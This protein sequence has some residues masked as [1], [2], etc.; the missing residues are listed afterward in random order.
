MSKLFRP[1]GAISVFLV[2][3]LVPCL[4]L[5]FLYVDL[6]RIELS[7]SSVESTADTALNS[8]MAN[9]DTVLNEYY[10]LIAS[11]QDI[12]EYCT[13]SK[14]FFV[15]TLQANGVA[16]DQSNEI[17]S[18]VFTQMQGGDFS[19]ILQGKLVKGSE[20]IYAVENSGLGENPALIKEGVVE[21]MKYRA[22]IM[23]VQSI[24]DLLM[25]KGDTLK[26]D[27]LEAEKDAELSESRDEFSRTE[28]ELNKREF[29]TYYYYQVYAHGGNLANTSGGPADLDVVEIRQY[30]EDAIK[31]YE[32]LSKETMARYWISKNTIP[33]S[34]SHYHIGLSSTTNKDGIKEHLATG[35]SYNELKTL[36][37]VADSE[38]DGTYY[39]EWDTL[40]G[41][42]NNVNTK[43]SELKTALENADTAVEKYASKDY[44]SEETQTN[45]EQWY[46]FARNAISSSISDVN[47]KGD[48]L[49]KAYVK[50]LA[51]RDCTKDPNDTTFP[52][53]WESQCNTAK[54]S[55]YSAL[56]NIFDKYSTSGY[57]GKGAKYMTVKCA[58]VELSSGGIRGRYDTASATS[59][60]SGIASKIKGYRDQIAGYIEDLDFVING[61]GKVIK[62]EVYSL[63][64]LEGLVWEYY[65]DYGD[66]EDKTTNSETTLGESQQEDLSEY[67]KN[68]R[69]V[70]GD[71]VAKFKEKLE[72]ERAALQGII[73]DLDSVKFGNKKIMDIK[74]F[75]SFYS[76]FKSE[77]TK[78]T[79][80]VTNQYMEDEGYRIYYDLLT[81][82]NTGALIQKPSCKL[83]LEQGDDVYYDFLL[84]KGYGDTEASLNDLKGK[85]KGKEGKLDDF[86][87]QGKDAEEASDDVKTGAGVI[88]NSTDVNVD[89]YASGTFGLTNVLTGFGKTIESIFS[90]GEN[91]RDSLYSTLY[92][93]N[94]FSYRTFV[95]EG[96]Y[97][98]YSH[99]H[100]DE[101]T[102]ENCDEK[103][104]LVKSNWSNTD[105][106][107]IYNKSL[108]NHMIDN[109]NNAAF[110]AEIE[111]ILYGGT[112]KSNLKDAYTSIYELR[113]A[114]NL[115]S[116]FVNFWKAG[117]N[118]TAD[119]IN[120]AADLI[121]QVTRGIVP[122]PLTKCILI[123]L[124]AA[125]E[126]LNDMK[127]LLKG[128]PLEVYKST[129]EQWAYSIGSKGSEKD[130]VGLN[131][132]K[133]P[134]KGTGISMQYSDY[135]F[136]FLFSAFSS[137][138][139]VTRM[140][141]GRLGRLI[142][143][144]IQ[145]Q[146]KG[147]GSYSLKNS[148]TM[149]TLT[150]EIEV[151]PMMM[152]LNLASDFRG[153]LDG[154]DW[155]KYTVK[156]SRGY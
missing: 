126:S 31:D 95:Y 137:G 75:D 65:A 145:I 11:V 15:K 59:T 33:D 84:G 63:D 38:K 51:M 5:C 86:E 100:N 98:D 103:Y 112:N 152:D 28:G 123:G 134:K 142:E 130:D 62:H 87:K 139:E 128:V 104:N 41:A 93:M 10:G 155:N 135:L 82:Q 80:Y 106:V 101:I 125:L 22:P 35:G 17:F 156:I 88:D 90:G 79:D 46:Y 150:T 124:L 3:I 113:L 19:D 83:V 132:P 9:Y 45:K 144:N 12:D 13:K 109:A 127:I 36:K 2:I 16:E 18:W 64:E 71:D 37:D 40:E 148:K 6:S 54:D 56:S 60:L 69:D 92:A 8:L 76:Q 61:D 57:D 27:L 105:P 7:K 30:L 140:A 141:Y 58:L 52:N 42:K 115:A 77:F 122:A 67:Q 39:I 147:D 25:D 133:S 143:A 74:D 1:G 4:V 14:E 99:D 146:K 119:L 108:T 111:Y 78:P 118:T 81:P 53:D 34:T 26:N 73:D 48:A 114:L 117:K 138:D 151:E 153:Q 131:D 116:G 66:W 68:N 43:L 89:E 96:L 50:L 32:D 23:A 129:D 94:M 24:F 44:G 102:F 110:N 55:A 91:V 136:L 72:K 121:A 29:Y 20:N 154:G 70:D 47:K 120:G 97:D 85:V 21:F 149:F 49:A 107:Y